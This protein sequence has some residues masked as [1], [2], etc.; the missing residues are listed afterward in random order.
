MQG[1]S[2][3]SVDDLVQAMSIGGISKSH[4]RE[5]GRI[6]LVE[7]II[8]I[9]A[10]TDG[11]REVL[12]MRAGASEAEP[13]WTDFLHSL[14]RRGLHGIKPVISDAHQGGRAQGNLGQLAALPSPFHAKPPRASASRPAPR[15]LRV[16]GDHLCADPPS[17]PPA[18]SDASFAISC[19][20]VSRGSPD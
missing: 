7:A 9:G 3:R 4:V 11:R 16:G 20:S 6:V 12:G 15:R 8:A 18:T 5:A 10:N 17:A 1:I 13:F 2:T 14:T 19:A